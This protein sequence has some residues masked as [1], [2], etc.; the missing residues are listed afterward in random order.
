MK[1]QIEH[2]GAQLVALA[3]QL[4]EARCQAQKDGVAVLRFDEEI[5]ITAEIITTGG[6]N[7]FIRPDVTVSGIGVTRTVQ[8]EAVVRDESGLSETATTAE[9][10]TAIS[11]RVESAEK[12]TTK[13]IHPGTIETTTRGATP[14]TEVVSGTETQSGTTGTGTSGID[15][16]TTTNSYAP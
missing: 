15:V 8:G 7:A 9:G 16:R 14:S 6:L 3:K 13:D 4:R 11:T 10:F 2:L 12:T 1:I 5:T